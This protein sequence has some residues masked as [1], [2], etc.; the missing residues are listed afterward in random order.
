MRRR[1]LVAKP[2]SEYGPCT[3]GS[4]FQHR[5]PGPE[6]V[7]RMRV[8]KVDSDGGGSEP[9]VEFGLRIRVPHAGS[10]GKG[11]KSNNHRARYILLN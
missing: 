11:A 7:N 4:E 2:R 9:E 10:R 8:P 1:I 6:C 3:K 5:V